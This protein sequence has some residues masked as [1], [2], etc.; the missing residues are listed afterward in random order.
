M[1]AFRDHD[2]FLCHFGTKKYNTDVHI[3]AVYIIA[4]AFLLSAAETKIY[5]LMCSQVVSRDFGS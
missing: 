3:T 5:S 2:M 1:H 4:E